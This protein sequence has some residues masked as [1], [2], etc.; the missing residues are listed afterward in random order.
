MIDQKL[1]A[2][3][4]KPSPIDNKVVNSLKSFSV[5]CL[6]ITLTNGSD[7]LYNIDLDR[8]YIVIHLLCDEVTAIGSCYF[9][10]SG[11][12]QVSQSLKMSI[13]DLISH[14]DSS[15]MATV[16]KIEKSLVT[17]ITLSLIK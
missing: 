11:K 6:G 5:T 12:I 3:L 13:Y 2:E 8:R 10:D 15:D 16:L 1:L 9:S 17:L 7:I 14:S 4:K